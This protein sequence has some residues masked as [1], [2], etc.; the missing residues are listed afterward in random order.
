MRNSADL[1]AGSES[2]LR[3]FLKSGRS[4]RAALLGDYRRILRWAAAAGGALVVS[5]ALAFVHLTGNPRQIDAPTGTFLSGAEIPSSIRDVI[6]NKCIDCHSEQTRWPI[7]SRLAPASWLLE[8][9]IVEARSHWNLSRWNVYS[10]E[11]QMKLLSKVGLKAKLAAMPP[12]RYTLL[13]P[14]SKLTPTESIALYEWTR[15]ERHR[16]LSVVPSTNK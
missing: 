12:A 11:E 4:L 16:L 15:T 3:E 10:P 13:H 7:Y 9:D 2:V 6:A 1:A 8:H 14:G 5:F